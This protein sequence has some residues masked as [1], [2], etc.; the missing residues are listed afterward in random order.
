MVSFSLQYNQCKHCCAQSISFM[1][2]RREYLHMKWTLIWWSHNS[3]VQNS[4]KIHWYCVTC[5][6]SYAFVGMAALRNSN[7]IICSTFQNTLAYFMLETDAI[8]CQFGFS[9]K[10]VIFAV[11][12]VMVSLVVVMVMAMV[13]CGRLCFWT[14]F[15]QH[16]FRFWPMKWTNMGYPFQI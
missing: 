9:C 3:F 14:L 12:L 6:V 10:S 2:R 13:F 8:I 16:N 11:L 5:A 15:E 4:C 7:H 1:F